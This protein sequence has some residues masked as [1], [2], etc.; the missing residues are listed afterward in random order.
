MSD[1]APAQANRRAS[2][3]VKCGRCSVIF[4]TRQCGKLDHFSIFR[5]VCPHCGWPGRYLASELHA[6]PVPATKAGTKR[7]A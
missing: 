5:I 3:S 6:M 2:V 4:A 1:H 7:A